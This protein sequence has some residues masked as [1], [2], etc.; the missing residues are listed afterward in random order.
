MSDL[1]RYRVLRQHDGDRFYE[2]GETRF[3][4][5][6]EVKHLIP[7]VL[8]LDGPATAAEVESIIA[9][10]PAAPAIKV[11]TGRKPKDE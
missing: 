11:I 5:E 7:L 4:R 8:E 2:A 1:L 3:A 9:I 10:D 6:A